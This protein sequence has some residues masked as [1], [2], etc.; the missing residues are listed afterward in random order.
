MFKGKG[1]KNMEIKFVIEVEK[2]TP[3]FY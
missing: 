3:F 1:G 2:K